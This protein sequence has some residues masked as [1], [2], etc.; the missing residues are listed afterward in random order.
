MGVHGRVWALFFSKQ[1][2]LF[3][4]VCFRSQ[5]LGLLF[6]SLNLN[7]RVVLLLIFFKKKI[8]P[9]MSMQ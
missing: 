7:D 8:K 4:T 5:K 2:G 6:L 3:A 9:Y 1:L